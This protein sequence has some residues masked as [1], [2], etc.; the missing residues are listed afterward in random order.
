MSVAVPMV[1]P[2]MMTDA[3]YFAFYRARISSLGWERYQQC[4]QAERRKYKTENAIDVR[5]FCFH[6]WVLCGCNDTDKKRGQIFFTLFN[7]T[8]S[9]PSLSNQ[10]R[11]SRKKRIFAS[12]YNLSFI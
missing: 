1:V 3:P 7:I 4:H 5:M 9:S 8:S 2:A 6:G 11:E 12:A 10:I